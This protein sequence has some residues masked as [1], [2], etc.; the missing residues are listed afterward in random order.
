MSLASTTSSGPRA[1]STVGV[2]LC[3][4][5]TGILVAAVAWPLLA[6]VPGL[7][8]FALA[9]A[10]AT[11]AF[12]AWRTRRWPASVAAFSVAWTLGVLSLGVFGG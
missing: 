8:G 5:W 10:V 3:G 9:A 12:V 1:A 2:G 6:R 7:L 11:G 4:F